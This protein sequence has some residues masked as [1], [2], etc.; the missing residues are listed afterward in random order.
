MKLLRITTLYSAYLKKFYTAHPEMAEKS[1]AEQ[2]AVLDY[3]AFGWADFWSH[4]L[5]PLGYDVAEVTMNAEPMQRAWAKENSLPNAERM[6]LKEIALAQV[7]SFKSEIL[8]CDDPNEDL[9]KQIRL[10][11]PSIKLVIGWVGSAIPQTNVWRQMDLI[12]SCAPES[13]RY[14]QKVGFS[15]AQLYHGFDPRINDRLLDR[16]KQI[17][18]SFVGQLIWG[19]QFHLQRKELLEELAAEIG[20]EIFSPS[21]DVS[22]KDKIKALL[23]AVIYWG[24]KNA[25]IIGFSESALKSFSFLSRAAEWTSLPFPSFNRKLKPYI[26]PAVYGLEMFQVLRDSQVTLNIHAD[27]SPF[28]A[29]NMRLFETTGVG[30]CLVTDWK[31][32]LHK[33]FEPDKEVVTYRSAEECVEKVKWLLE[34]PE[35]RKEIAKAGQKRCLRDHTFAQ[36]VHKLDEIIQRALA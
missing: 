31:K 29:S 34:H 9:L 10:E 4:A 16:P 27:S 25:R 3:D 6:D 33:L 14:L 24:I 12:L 17:D 19:N 8:W 7:K 18:F 30:T 28:F 35:E 23:M 5:T 22:W 20:I 15:A 1:Y 13:V 11:I 26:K 2:R 21:A 36:R 32:N